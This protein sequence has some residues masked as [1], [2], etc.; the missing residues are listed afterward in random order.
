MIANGGAGRYSTAQRG[1]GS[2]DAQRRQRGKADRGDRGDAAATRRRH[3]FHL[4]HETYNLDAEEKIGQWLAAGRVDLFAFNDH[5]DITTAL[6]NKPRKRAAMVERTGLSDEAFDRLV[7]KVLSRAAEVPGSIARLAAIARESKVRMLSHDD[8]T[9][10]ARN[11]FRALGAAIAEFPVNE[12]TA[13]EAAAGGD[14]IVYGAPNVVRGGSH[15]GWTKAADMIAKGLCSVLASDYYYPAPL[16]A[17]F[18]LAADHVL[19]LA[20]AWDLVSSAPAHATG[21]TDRGTLA[22]GQRADILL[23]DDAMALRPRIVAVIVAGRL[24]YLADADRLVSAREQ[25]PSGGCGGIA[26]HYSGCDG[27]FPALCDLLRGGPRRRA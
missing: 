11:A 3:A 24:A 9:P 26:L 22:A 19:P 12:E 21:L 27:S 4:R 16:L 8:K 5:M 23:V 1:R 14:A 7:E 25:P 15:T 10:A 18:R 17:P 13:R 2:L 6:R 20:R